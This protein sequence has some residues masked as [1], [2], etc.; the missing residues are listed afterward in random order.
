MLFT[1][2]C[3]RIL[4]VHA[5]QCAR[6]TKHANKHMFLGNRREHEFHWWSSVP[7]RAAA[8]AIWPGPHY[9]TGDP[10]QR[11][12]YRLE[13]C[14]IYRARE[15][16]RDAARAAAAAAAAAGQSGSCSRDV[17]PVEQPAADE[18][19]PSAGE[20]AGPPVDAV[21]SEDEE[22][23]DE[24]EDAAWYG[25]KM[26]DSDSEDEGGPNFGGRGP[27]KLCSLA[28]RG[29]HDLEHLDGY[30]VN[31]TW[32]TRVYRCGW[33]KCGRD[34]GW[35][36]ETMSVEIVDDRY[37]PSM[38]DRSFDIP[39]NC[40]DLDSRPASQARPCACCLCNPDRWCVEQWE[41][42]EVEAKAEE[43]EA[44]AKQKQAKAEKR[45][46]K[47]KRKR[48]AVAKENEAPEEAAGASKKKKMR[49]DSVEAGGDGYACPLC[50]ECFDTPALVRRARRVRPRSPPHARSSVPLTRAPAAARADA[51][52]LEGRVRP[53]RRAHRRRGRLQRVHVAELPVVVQ[54]RF[55]PCPP[56]PA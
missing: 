9:D 19:V 20:G 34:M 36:G 46:A 17:L 15:R 55:T 56:C 18:A 38:G 50:A 30:R 1:I 52:A 2:R 26:M 14:I 43:E 6:F 23:E 12:S 44:A 45:E 21:D 37:D 35:E 16:E 27:G 4:N 25:E 32:S 48:E 53:E 22:D 7:A 40:V 41:A 54:R 10:R 39:A 11:R 28:I 8:A 49:F 13:A 31:V 5:K 47:K 29:H 24:D 3:Y 42:W 51:R 33:S